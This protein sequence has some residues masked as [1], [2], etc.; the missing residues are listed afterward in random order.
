MD[1]Q[2]LEN[3]VLELLKDAPG[4]GSIH[5]NKGL[6]LIDAYYHSLFLKTLTGIN[7]VKHDLG[8]VP[9]PQAYTVLYEMELNANKIEVR[10]EKRGPVYTQNAHY[11]VTEPDYTVFPPQAVDIIKE[12]ADM[13]KHM[14]ASRLSK[15]THNAV[16]EATPKGHIIPIESAYNA[17]VVSRNVRKLKGS[18]REQAQD[19]LE[20]LYGSNQAGLSV[21]CQ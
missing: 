6:L 5:I 1:K 3:T 7:Y 10:P 13:I 4:I 21:V 18:E 8:P 2:M 11:A 14:T 20:R 19:M 9:E 17:Q 12:V 15:I 16:W